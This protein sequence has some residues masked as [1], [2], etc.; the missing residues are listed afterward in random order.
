VDYITKTILV[1]GIKFDIYGNEKD[2]KDDSNKEHKLKIT[3]STLNCKESFIL[4]KELMLNVNLDIQ[5]MYLHLIFNGQ[6]DCL[7]NNIK[8]NS[9]LSHC[10]S[11]FSCNK[12]SLNTYDYIN[13]IKFGIIDI[14]K[15][16]TL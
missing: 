16:I 10:N 6:Y 5:H 8:I 7:K 13:G 11:K 4:L 2:D 12:D 15:Y 1:N 3:L 14:N 9:L